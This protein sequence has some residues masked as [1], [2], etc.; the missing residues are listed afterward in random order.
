MKQIPVII[1]LA[2]VATSLIIMS[3]F[4]TGESSEV[5]TGFRVL[6]TED[7]IPEKKVIEAL[8]Q[9]GLYKVV[10]H[11]TLGLPQPTHM[12][13]LYPPEQPFLDG[14]DSWFHD[15]VQGLRFMYLKDSALLETK[16]Q[17]A[18]EDLPVEWTLEDSYSFSF[19]PS[20]FSALLCL[21]QLI[22]LRRRL[23]V[24]TTS[25]PFIFLSLA[26]PTVPVLTSVL[27]L[28]HC[29]AHA[30]QIWDCGYFDVPIRQRLHNLFNR[31]SLIVLISIG[32]A[33]SAFSGVLALVSF[34]AAFLMALAIAFIH[35]NVREQLR[36]LQRQKKIRPDF[37]PVPIGTFWKNRGITK[38]K[39]LFLALI[40][41]FIGPF[42]LIAPLFQ[43]SA[44]GTSSLYGLSIPSP[45]GYTVV[46]GFSAS[47]FRI[48]RDSRLQGL[49]DLSDY[50]YLSW[51]R[52]GFPYR[53]V[54]TQ[55]EEP[56]PGSTI[57]YTDYQS[58]ETGTL[59]PVEVT[60]DIFDDDFI[61]EV[62]NDPR[63]PLL[64][65]M[66]KKQGRFISVGLQPA[67]PGT[68]SAGDSFF[69]LAVLLPLG[70][71]LIRMKK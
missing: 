24:F 44:G 46:H 12:P 20:V 9:V 42:F 55:A 10:A 14:F 71:V 37:R 57:S 59:K 41:P 5:W 65:T 8:S 1:A 30:V 62:L 23:L 51:D 64:F 7:S 28:I 58:T 66:M 35:E 38:P 43:G 56:L 63:L 39:R 60:I 34:L 52:L 32:I 15:P 6:I 61:S 4:R 54:L 50:V 33:L 13:L 21:I 26:S 69:L 19:L 48:H 47:S 36:I 17:K 2:L 31:P 68:N 45:S 53:P 67:L 16:T 40:P 70:T 27:L 3:V 18:F 11:S 25:I 49:T 22:V 29:T